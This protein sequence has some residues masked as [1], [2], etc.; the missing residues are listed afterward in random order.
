[1]PFCVFFA[2]NAVPTAGHRFYYATPL[3]EPDLNSLGR[4]RIDYET[5]HPISAERVEKQ[6]SVLKTL[7]LGTWLD[8]EVMEALLSAFPNTLTSF[9]K[10]WNPTRSRTGQGYNLS[11]ELEQMPAA[12]LSKLKDFRPPESGFLIDFENLKTFK[13]NNGKETVYWTKAKELYEKPLVIIPQSPGDDDEGPRAY[14]SDQSMAFSQSFYGYSCAGHPEAETLAALLYLLPHSTLF[15]YFCLMTSR[16]SGFDRQTF[17]KEE[18]D[19]L[20]FPELATLKATDKTVLCKLAHRL[21]HDVAKPW[22]E[23]DSLLFRLYGLDDD[24][25]QVAED[26]IFAAASYR[27]AG[28]AALERTTAKSRVDFIAELRESLELYFDVC[29]EHAAVRKVAHQPDEWNEPWFFLA[30][31]READTVPVNPSLLRNAMK[32]ANERGTSRVLVKA[33]GCRGLLLGLLN[34]RRWWTGTR[35]RLCGQHIIREYLGAFGLPEST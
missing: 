29:G 6:P 25:V 34:Q 35:A 5:T 19:A 26:T 30:V 15:D 33:S 1:M 3:N 32:I 28:Q 8:V 9:W 7:S 11:N 31:S 2:R 20:P 21:E 27:K 4:F 22:P 23:I 14:R 17:N 18:F 10:K 13:E 12:F 24:A 16:R